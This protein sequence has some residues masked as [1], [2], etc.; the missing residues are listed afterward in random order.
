MET[1]IVVKDEDGILR[2]TAGIWRNND[3]GRNMAVDYQA[4]NPEV[5]IVIVEMKE[6][7]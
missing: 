1:Y 6:Q 5:S 4:K 3:L 7:S 2:P